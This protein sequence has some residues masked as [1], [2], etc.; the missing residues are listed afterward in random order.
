HPGAQDLKEEKRVRVDLR[1]AASVPLTVVDGLNALRRGDRVPGR[2]VLH[3]D[4]HHRPPSGLERL[5]VLD[6]EAVGWKNCLLL[7][8]RSEDP[9]DV[10]RAWVIDAPPGQRTLQ[11]LRW[12]RE[13]HRD[14]QVDVAHDRTAGR[15]HRR[16]L[17]GLAPG[18]GIAALRSGAEETV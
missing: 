13:S 3:V 5:L 4:E 2:E 1:E 11:R 8:L 6:H 14:Q 15:W 16:S 17:T 7:V 9:G 18:G 12:R 10:D